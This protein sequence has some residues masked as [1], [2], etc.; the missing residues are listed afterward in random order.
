MPYKRK[1]NQFWEGKRYHSLDYEL[2]S[3]FGKKLYKLSLNG[4]MSCPNRDGT[5]GTGGCIFCSKG[6]SGDFSAAASMPVAG[7]IEEA[8]K[9]VEKKLP[10]HHSTQY[11]AYFQ[12]FTNT[13][14]PVAYLERIF[15]EAIRHPDIAILSIAT[16][17][18]CLGEDVL[19]LLRRLH[20]IKP[21]WIELGLQTSHEDTARWIRRGYELAVF[22]EAVRKLRLAGI[23]VIVHTILGLP[24]ESKDDILKTMEYIGGLSD[25]G[26]I[27][28][29]K[30]QLMHILDGTELG[31]LYLEDKLPEY[32]AVLSMEDYISLVISCLEHL[33]R[34]LVIHRLTGDGPKE[35]L[36]APLWSGNKRL[37]LNTLH[38]T[39]K[40]RDS[41]QGK[42]YT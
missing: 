31:R 41:W 33:P 13:H 37:V 4:G 5:I 42:Y 29:I 18:D 24:G 36:L 7:Q 16:R 22:E 3:T 12:A 35:I 25:L 21:V 30:L 10:Y 2:K 32:R 19:S 17:P 40:E 8:K 38:R 27:Q 14:A 26:L 20:S 39:M 11:I 1:D 23:P 34:E 15:T 6:G 28:G 9:L